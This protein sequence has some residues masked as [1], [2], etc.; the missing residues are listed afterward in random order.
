MR[1][2]IAVEMSWVPDFVL[3]PMQ[4]RPGALILCAPRG[5][6][7]GEAGLAV[8]RAGVLLHHVHAAR[9]LA[10]VRVVLKRGG[11]RVVPAT[12]HPPQVLHTAPLTVEPH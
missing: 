8:V 1:R 10:L 6:H 12:A 4:D 9:V 2:G 11:A 7:R 5:A 3:S